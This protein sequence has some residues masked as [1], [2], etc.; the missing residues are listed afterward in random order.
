MAG[1][2]DQSASDEMFA[3]VAIGIPLSRS[4][5]PTDV[6]IFPSRIKP[7]VLILEQPMSSALRLRV[8][9]D[10]QVSSSNSPATDDMNPLLM[11]PA[12]MFSALRD[13]TSKLLKE[14]MAAPPLPM[15][16]SVISALRYTSCDWILILYKP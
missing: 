11:Y 2:S 10:E 6:R 5:E 7:R 9:N 13:D 15:T 8:L 16:D 1:S 3:V 14:L 4:S 12:V